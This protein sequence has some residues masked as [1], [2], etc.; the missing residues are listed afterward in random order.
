MKPD[1]KA[2]R[3]TSPDAQFSLSSAFTLIELLVVIAII[4][5]LASMLLPALAKA[6]IKAQ[7]TSCLSQ[8]K[9][10]QLCYLLYIDDNRDV[11]PL[12]H[13][14]PT[15]SLKDSWV[16]GDAKRDTSPTNIQNGVLYVYNSS[17]TIYRCP[18][19][20]S[21]TSPTALE[22]RGLPRTRSY[23]IDYALSGDNARLTKAAQIVAPGP[24]Q[25]SVFW[26]EQEDS[27]D[28]GGFGIAPRRDLSWWN[29][30]ASRHGKSCAI[31]FMD[32]HVEG[33][34]WHG[35]SV[36]KFLSYGQATSKTDPDLPRV[37]NTTPFDF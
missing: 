6:K 35:T 1:R 20:K 12:N 3:H 27:I 7:Q 23:A 30:P 9:Q 13:A 21:R 18:G 37:Q 2:V 33:W 34:R 4:A 14:V 17:V 5:I 8:L 22:K 31:S 29:L 28:N 24:S 32:G 16:V 11:L 19:D 10:L 25:K 15:A 36:L 26:D